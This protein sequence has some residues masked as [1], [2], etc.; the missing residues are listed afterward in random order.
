VPRNATAN[1]FRVPASVKTIAPY[2]FGGCARITAIQFAGAVTAFGQGAFSGTGLT[3]FRIPASVTSIGEECFFECRQLEAVTFEQGTKVKVLPAR[4]L[5]STDE[6][7]SFTVPKSVV[8]IEEKAFGRTPK[9]TEVGFEDESAC[10]TI[11]VDAFWTS[12]IGKLTLPPKLTTLEPNFFACCSL[13]EILIPPSQR[14]FAFVNGIL[15]TR[16]NTRLIFA[17]RKISGRFEIPKQVQV[18]SANA[19][20]NCELLE[21]VTFET[22]S[23]LRVIESSAFF[24]T[25]LKRITIPASV[26]DIGDGA[27]GNCGSLTRVDFAE[28]SGLVRIGQSAF[29]RTAL[30]EFTGPPN[31][32]T[33]GPSAFAFTYEL[34]SAVLPPSVLTLPQDLFGG[35]DAIQVVRSNAPS[36]STVTIEVRAF[37]DR[38]ERNSFR[39]NPGVRVVWDDGDWSDD[40]EPPPPGIEHDEY[41]EAKPYGT[42][43]QSYVLKDEERRR[44]TGLGHT[45][46]AL[47]YKARHVATR[48]ISFVKEFDSVDIDQFFKQR[49]FFPALAHPGFVGMIGVVMPTGHCNAKIVTEFITGGSLAA[50]ITDR[51]RYAALPPTAKVKI[52]VGVVYAMR[53]MH[54]CGLFHRDLKPDNILIDK[55][56]EPRI[57]DF[58]LAR[59]A[60]SGVLKTTRLTGCA[61]Y[62]A[63]E[64]ADETYDHMVDI[65]SFAM[66]LWEI[67]T[68]KKIKEGYARD[69]GEHLIMR[70]AKGK[71]LRPSIA[72]IGDI[73]RILIE[74]SWNSKPQDRGQGFAQI[75]EYLKD[76]A[77]SVLEAV[78]ILE[79]ERYIARI[80]DFE[81]RHPPRNLLTEGE[82]DY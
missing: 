73:A 58:R 61:Y 21:E 6:L 4:F 69:P 19:F 45:G 8:E 67:V 20:C 29:R 41:E 28:G 68:G 70:E 15:S 47:A 48:K 54:G 79:I 1:P 10:T 14:A 23:A 11:K 81:G 82:D 42:P 18:V 72:G 32:T 55:H 50:L 62:M 71:G 3:S 44:E 64:L 60:E 5:A 46:I 31:L 36:G 35:C 16:D 7:K 75:A 9:L 51:A 66:I 65:Y 53:Y 43:T 30:T 59:L 25:G 26:T 63:P 13:T 56:G 57:S 37:S 77:Y 2:A 22:P 40:D 38:F 78:N 12:N 74:R 39:V 52:V 17:Q 33:F 76:K 27:F 34:K 49:E 80:E 24:S